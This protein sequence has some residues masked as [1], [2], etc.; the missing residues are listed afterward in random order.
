MEK[1]VGESMTDL[2]YL[3]MNTTKTWGKKREK[4]TQQWSKDED[5][6]ELLVI[7]SYLK[8]PVSLVN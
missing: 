8:S 6:N 2:E 1:K 4:T 5:Q 7:T 3:K